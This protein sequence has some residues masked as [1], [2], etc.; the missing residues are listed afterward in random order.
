[1]AVHVSAE[2]GCPLRDLADQ[3]DLAWREARDESE[4]AYRAWCAAAAPQR[5]L[6]HAVFLA[7]ADREA[8]AEKAFLLTIDPA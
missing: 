7:A 6:A 5:R 3:L 8:T 4:A 1:M 2:G